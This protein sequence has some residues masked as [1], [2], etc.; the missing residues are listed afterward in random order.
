MKNESTY[1]LQSANYSNVYLSDSH[2]KQQFDETVETYLNIP[3]DSLLNIFR[4]RAGLPAPGKTLVGWYGRG[5]STFGQKLGAFAKMYKATGDMRIKQKALYLAGEWIKCVD[6]NPELINQGTYVFDKLIGGFI[7]MYECM[8]FAPAMKYVE[9]LTDAAIKNFKKDVKRDGLQ[10]EG[11]THTGMIEWYTLPENLYKA[12]QITGKEKYKEFAL[13]WDYPYFW[14]KILSGD[15]YFGA[16]HAYS[17]VNS[18]SSAAQA[19]ITTKDKKYLKTIE[20]AY[21]Q[22]TSDQI[23]VTGGYGPAESMF[24]NKKGYLGESILPAWERV[25]EASYTHFA[26]KKTIRDDRWGSCEVSCCAWAI[27]KICNYLMILTGDAKYGDWA[28]KMLY[29]GT[30]G[31]PPITSDGHVL[32]YASYFV[33]GAVKSV[34]DRKMHVGGVGFTWQCCTGTFP[35]DVAEYYNMAYYYDE[36][37]VYVN[38]YLPSLFTWEKDGTKIAIENFSKYPEESQLKF[39]VN[40]KKDIN[41]DLNFRIPSWVKSE[42]KV[43][44]N[45]AAVD[46]KCAPNQWCTISREWKDGDIITL[47]IPFELYFTPV[48]SLHPDIVA[49]N[50]GPIVLATDETLELVGDKSNPSEWI[51]PVEGKEMEFITDEGHVGGY[52]FLTRTFRPYYKVPEMEWYFMYNKIVTES[53]PIRW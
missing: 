32:Y 47:D 9:K 31:Q 49:L 30:G 22:I 36:S 1:K 11:L 21:N 39:C 15:M 40:T 38:Q 13:E 44:V 34:N 18:L 53:A 5:A 26:G 19:Y 48:D 3:N 45:E 50:Y 16:R 43:H 27:F 42:V 14:D 7:D 8:D 28:E 35:Q 17:H 37:G 24:V 20:E 12:Y 41:F 23:F 33:D 2:W 29:N 46:A 6:H 25:D 10:D 51:H 52:D 4:T